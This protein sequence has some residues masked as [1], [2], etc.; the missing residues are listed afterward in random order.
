MINRTACSKV[1][2]PGLSSSPAARS[3]ARLRL[4]AHV[5]SSRRDLLASTTTL[6]LGLCTA[7]MA[8]LPPPQ[9]V[10]ALDP[11]GSMRPSSPH[12]GAVGRRPAWGS[13][14]AADDFITTPSGLRY[15]DI[16]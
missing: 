6:T 16:K 12:D 3:A 11:D 5:A 10:G 13:A 8:V 4:Q 15:Y 14:L 9:E 7:Q 1:T 2:G